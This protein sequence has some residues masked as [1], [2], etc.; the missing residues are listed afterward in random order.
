[1]HPFSFLVIALRAALVLLIG[2]SALL[3]QG[4]LNP[5]GAP[6]PTM[7][8]LDQLDTKLEKRIPISSLPFSITQGGSYYF[9]TNLAGAGSISVEADNVTVD[10]NG[11]TLGGGPGSTA[12]IVVPS[13]H[14]N[15]CIRNGVIEGRGGVAIS[16]FN[17]VNS[18]ITDLR[19]TN[20]FGGIQVGDSALVLRCLVRGNTGV[21]NTAIYAGKNALVQHCQVLNNFYGIVVSDASQVLNCVAADNTGNGIYGGGAENVLVQN[22]Q[23][24]KNAGDG[25]RLGHASQTLSCVTVENGGNGIYVNRA[26]VVSG[27]LSKGNFQSGIYVFFENGQIMG[28]TCSWNNTG[29]SSSHANIFIDDDDNHVEGNHVTGTG[30]GIKVAVGFIRN[31]IVRNTASNSGANNY[32]IAAG[33][34]AGPISTAALATSPWANISH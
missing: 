22:C 18:Q 11:F 6:L 16:A 7:K 31:V 28:N 26:C 9:T 14:S 33:N 30:T 34:D 20:N 23:A 25:I 1:M 15:L 17:T 13:A 19:V 32:V 2:V 24:V 4:P 27:C 21:G 8:T 5:P 10:L 12:G 3:A 29:S